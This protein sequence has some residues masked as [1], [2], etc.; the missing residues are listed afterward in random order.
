[1]NE[2]SRSP[3]STR[4]KSGAAR[5][6]ADQ[7]RNR[8]CG[9]LL[10]MS[11]AILRE[12]LRSMIAQCGF[13]VF[14][15]QAT[16]Q[17]FVLDDLVVKKCRI[18]VVD[19]SDDVDFSRTKA[20]VA[21]IRQRNARGHIVVLIPPHLA[22]APDAAIVAE[23]SAIVTTDVTVYVLGNLLQL[24]SENYVVR[25]ANVAVAPDPA[26]A[27]IADGAGP[28]GPADP[29]LPRGDGNV[30]DGNIPGLSSRESEILLHLIR[31][32]SNK[33]IARALGIAEA[34]VKIHIK[35]IFR[36]TG[37]TNR[38]QA[39]FYVFNKRWLG[40]QTA[41]Q[42]DAGVPPLQRPNSFRN[43]LDIIFPNGGPR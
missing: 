16:H 18:Y 5:R 17:G 30:P 7:V 10:A 11:N 6:D 20:F 32:S 36:K 26:G 4:R 38:T 33:D 24:V 14:D 3:A 27:G 13:R 31:G 39:A 34:T 19:A 42:Q 25:S 12:G 41:G 21:Q 9:V 8:N 43:G 40:S 15:C 2:K 37:A 23:A 29:L 1:M 22:N 35:G 28:P